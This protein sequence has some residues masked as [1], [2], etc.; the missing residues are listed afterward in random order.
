LAG[1]VGVFAIGEASQA[2]KR[3][4]KPNLHSPMIHNPLLL[5]PPT[6]VEAWSQ[7]RSGLEQSHRGGAQAW[8]LLNSAYHRFVATND[9]HGALL[10]A[11]AL[12]ITGQ[13]LG[14]FRDFAELLPRL[15]AMKQTP[16]PVH[17]ADE[18]LLGLT[19]LL[20]G[21]VMYDLTDPDA[22][23]CATR[24]VELLQVDVEINLRLAAARVLIFYVEPLEKRELAQR[25]NALVQPECLHPALT[26]HRLGHWL[27]RWRICLG[28]AG[29]VQQ[30]SSVGEAI[31]EL[32]ERHG[33]RDLRFLLAFDAVGQCL[34][35]GDIAGAELALARA[36]ALVD[37][38]HLRELMLL[39]VC[40]TRIARAKGQGD[41]ALFRAARA[42]KYAVELQCPG[43][44][45][46]AYIVNEAQ[47]RILVGDF[48]GAGRQMEEAVLL[49]PPGFAVEIREMIDL[50]DAYVAIHVD[51]AAG[52]SLLAAVWARMRER[53]FYDAFEGYP[54]FGAQLCML[55][56]AHAIEVDFVAGVIRRQRLAAPG[57]ADRRW[58]W[59]LRI[60]ALGRFELQRDGVPLTVDGKAQKKPLELL[61][62]LV[63]LGATARHRGADVRELVELL[64]PDLEANAP[65]ASFDMTLMR[66]R[67]WL[68]VDGALR[69][70]EGCL[71]LDPAV[72][73]CDVREFETG[74]DE[75]A[76]LLRDEDPGVQP[77]ARA[78]TASGRTVTRLL[79]ANAGAL[80]G[81]RGGEAWAVSAQE[82][83]A[84]RH[85]EAV[86]VIG[87]H[88]EATS[89]WAAA[90]VAYE[91]GLVQDRVAE[92]MYR[93]LMRCHLQMGEPSAALRAYERCTA[94][95]QRALRVGAAA[96]TVTLFERIARL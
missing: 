56:L 23:R 84:R 52:R 83:L 20:V 94:Q 58:P 3:S 27:V 14:N 41:E 53:Q 34:P 82:A 19:A 91:A 93:G 9:A 18:E 95:L 6:Y 38:A 7:Y 42:R 59:P 32:T 73:W 57:E 17:S 22:E 80:F 24:I 31:L 85:L 49:V 96:E 86:L 36:E 11:A 26:P 81:G 63:A 16:P 10:S 89:D 50:I 13:L 61:R 47:A 33:L 69:L 46:A 8:S 45:L 2:L 28:F 1:F 4:R 25:V 12:V 40:R 5:S 30:Q 88:R 87:A 62:A 77:S 76:A 72:V 43:P 90:I 44:M 70:A 48:S 37:P 60:F 54:Q 51:A 15:Q 35:G 67:K 29:E 64:W 79:A 65:K 74:A 66:L 21:Q 92:A 75:L 68:Q 39:D 71:W 78:S 55:A